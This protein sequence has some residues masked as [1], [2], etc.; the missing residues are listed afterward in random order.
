MF[1]SIKNAITARFAKDVPV[2]EHS[3]L[4]N[5]EIGQVLFLHL[6]KAAGSSLSFYIRDQVKQN[7]D[8]S[9]IL[10]HDHID[11]PKSR[12][13]AIETARTAKYVHG[14]FSW[15]T[16][17]EVVRDDV[18]TFAFT[19]LR[20]PAERLI[21]LYLFM[22]S[23]PE[24]RLPIYDAVRKM[25]PR[26]FLIDNRNDVNFE[27]NNF[28]VRQFQG[29]VHDQISDMSYG[30]EMLERAKTNISQLD[31]V[32]FVDTFE[33]DFQSIAR[34]IG[35]PHSSDTA[36]KTNETVPT[37]SDREA[38]QDIKSELLEIIETEAQEL[39]YWDNMLYEHMKGLSLQKSI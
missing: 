30:A 29:N 18:P 38:V 20:D 15:N 5:P 9:S 17:R 10:L 1:S 22:R 23:K 7:N 19:I 37:Q 35:Y 16:Y 3:I 27:T 36:P 4:E 39:V 34:K 25:S 2:A 8:G 26:Q 12:K 11:H 6:P 14:H 24:G 31:Y 21:S 32:G 28:A 13:H 33:D